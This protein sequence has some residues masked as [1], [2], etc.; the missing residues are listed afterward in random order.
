MY[1]DAEAQGQEIDH[2]LDDLK[3]ALKRIKTFNT[4]ERRE[5]LNDCMSIIQQL[6]TARE[7]YMLELRSVSEEELPAHQSAL[8]E[9]M[10]VFK[11]LLQEYEFKKSEI[12]KEELTAEN[13]GV[14]NEY[15]NPDQMDQQQ[16]INYGD[17]VQ[18]K[19]QDSINR[20]AKMTNA[21]EIVGNETNLQIAGQIEQMTAIEMNVQEIRSDVK[22]AKTLATQIARNAAGDR[23]IQILLALVIFAAAGCVAFALIAQHTDWLP[24]LVTDE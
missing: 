6:R 5:R 14:I 12:N 2:L 4:E 16:L 22:R 13:A 11:Q 3:G 20:M 21:A 15:S 18:D 24:S 9:R 23:C 7:A 19:T 1:S 17:H 10:N 8:N